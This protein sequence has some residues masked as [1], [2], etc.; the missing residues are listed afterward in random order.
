MKIHNVTSCELFSCRIRD[1]VVSEV[2]EVI[3]FYH[4]GTSFEEAALEDRRRR[5]LGINFIL[6]S[7]SKHSGGLLSVFTAAPSAV[8]HRD[9]LWGRNADDRTTNEAT[10]Q[11]TWPIDSCTFQYFQL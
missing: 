8:C 3:E 9:G 11:M 10:E 1:C 6:L 2:I 7:E 5:N 4:R